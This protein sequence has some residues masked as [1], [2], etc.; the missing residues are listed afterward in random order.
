MSKALFAVVLALV[1]L[2]LAASHLSEADVVKMENRCEKLRQEKLAPQK[3]AVLKQCL[4]SGEGDRATCEAK[5]GA[6]GEIQ[7]GAIRRPGKYYDLPE[8]QESYRA[9]K[10]Y[11]INPGR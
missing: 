9:R 5:A 10:H 6:Y 2:P 8:C 4:D 3:A 11:D 1:S 7:T